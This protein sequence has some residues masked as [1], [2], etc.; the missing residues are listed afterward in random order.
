M[1]FKVSIYN[2]NLENKTINITIS[3]GGFDS[4]YSEFLREKNMD[5]YDFQE[6]W[7]N[8]IDI[9]YGHTLSADT[10]DKRK[11]KQFFGFNILE[12]F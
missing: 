8:F 11:L 4:R 5:L 6:Y 3:S 2:V 1:L 7:F 9:S 10:K 12:V